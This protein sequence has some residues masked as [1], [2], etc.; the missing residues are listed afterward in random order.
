VKDSDMVREATFAWDLTDGRI[1]PVERRESV[2]DD[3]L[4]VLKPPKRKRRH[5][6]ADDDRV[7]CARRSASAARDLA[8]AAWTTGDLQG[9]RRSRN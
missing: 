8:D 6:Q 4:L 2:L 5:K 1:E 9:H 7:P 3:D